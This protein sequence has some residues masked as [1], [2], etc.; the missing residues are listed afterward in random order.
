MKHIILFIILF[1]SLSAKSQNFIDLESG[2]H[3][4]IKT[5]INYDGK[6]LNNVKEKIDLISL[7]CKSKCKNEYSYKPEIIN[8]KETENLFYVIIFYYSCENSYGARSESVSTFYYDGI[9]YELFDN[10]ELG[11]YGST[12]NREYI[13]KHFEDI[14]KRKQ[15]EIKKRDEQRLI[16]EQRDLERRIEQRKLD[17]QRRIEKEKSYAEFQKAKKVRNG[18]LLGF[19]GVLIVILSLTQN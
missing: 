2:N 15:E 5:K 17:E 14:E 3:Q 7:L 1:I 6:N 16:Q 9:S 19:G 4:L 12:I 11:L 10:Y 8:I 13:K 18:I